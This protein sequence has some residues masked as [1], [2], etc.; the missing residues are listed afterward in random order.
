MPITI[1]RFRVEGPRCRGRFGIGRAGAF[2]AMAVLAALATA[3]TARSQS[4]DPPNI[5]V[6]LTDDQG[7]GDYSAFGTPD[8]QTPALDRLYREGAELSEFRANCPVCSPTRASL[9]TGCYPDRVGVPGVIRTAP[10]NSWG[11]LSPRPEL[12]PRLL[13]RA[14]YHTGMVGKWHLGLERPNTPNARGFDVFHG[15]LGDMMD[16]YNTHLRHGKNYM[17][18]NEREIAPAGH[19][20]DLFTDWA[21]DYLKDRSRSARPFFLYLAYN[22]PHDPIQP[23]PDWLARVRRSRPRLDSRRAGLAALIEHMDSGIGRV[24]DMLDRLD[25]T[26]STLLVFTSDNGGR[27][28]TGAVNGPWRSGKEHMYEGGLRVPAVVRW[29]GRIA[30]GHKSRW[31]AVTMDLLPTLCEAAGAPAGGDRDGISF[32]KE[33]TTGLQAVPERDLYFVRREGGP[34]YGGK[35]IEALIRKNWKLVLDSPFG[36]A[37]LYDLATDPYETTDLS[38]RQPARLAELRSA[39]QLRTQ[40]GGRTPWQPPVT[41]KSVP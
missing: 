7:R 22:A 25:L 8:L 31:P 5:V 10:E 3:D 4:V 40:D 34:A 41:R 37:E 14:G 23:P 18:R 28:Q 39:L 11:F 29:P 38:N 36:R 19:A 17:R 20:T 33:L 12:L 13:K 35:T 27:I 6:I 1:N 15:F 2:P 26:R 21:I 9:M 30:A 32:L 16:D 24:L